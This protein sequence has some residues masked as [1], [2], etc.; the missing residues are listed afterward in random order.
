MV[1]GIIFFA[2]CFFIFAS[3][4]VASSP[5]VLNEILPN[6]SGGGAEEGEYI[7]LYNSSDDSVDISS[8]SLDDQA[9][10]GS[11]PYVFPAD[12]TI[13]AHQFLSFFKSKTSVALNN[14]GDTV[15][16]INKDNQEVDSFSYDKV[17]EGVVF[18]RSP[19]GG[20]W[21]KL[22]A[23]TPGA[24]NS[25]ILPTSTPKPPPA[26]G[27]TPTQIPKPSSTPKP[28]SMTR[29]ASTPALTK[30][31]TTLV[32]TSVLIPSPTPILPD[33]VDNE[34]PGTIAGI[35]QGPV[36]TIQSSIAPAPM[37]AAMSDHN[38]TVG[39]LLL[40]LA[41]CSLIGGSIVLV[42]RRNRPL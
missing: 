29:P 41:G 39:M 9:D 19:D 22:T 42:K 6:P 27:P 11:K 33:F 20:S 4:I 26:G 34:S 32:A 8:W 2:G 10:G 1:S 14:S 24:P 15:R 31:A 21:S 25:P 18:G 38:R 17:D 36:V 3:S 12:T 16:L 35:Y 7:E 30:L 40:A 37:I 28:S 23:Q 5:I 13:S